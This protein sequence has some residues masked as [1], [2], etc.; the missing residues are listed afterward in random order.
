LPIQLAL[1]TDYVYFQHDKLVNGQRLNVKPSITLPLQNTSGFIIPKVSLQHTQYS[2]TNPNGTQPHDI[3]RTVPIVSVDSGLFGERELNWGEHSFT[4]TIEPRLFYLYIPRVKQN[5]IPVFDSSLYD[6]WYSNLF[7]ENRF[8]GLD[9]IQDAN[10]ITAAVSSRLIDSKTGLERLKLSIGEIFYLQ[11][12]DVTMPMLNKQGDFVNTQVETNKYSNLVT[13]LSSEI[14]RHL[15]VEAGLQWNP[16]SNDIQRGK[17]VLH[18]KDDNNRLLNL[19]YLYR[20]NPLLPDKSND[21]QQTDVSFSWPIYDTWSIVGRWQYSLLYNLTQEAFFGIEKE[22]C[23]WRF[24]LIGR[25][26]INGINNSTITDDPNQLA[27]GISQ[28]GIFFQIELKGLTGIG[29]K[30]DNFFEKSIYGYQK[31]DK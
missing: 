3:D 15:S 8:S 6:F 4:H 5:N 25:R 24:R 13:E 31:A 26:Y 7:R 17:A 21:I 12:R 28:T 29:E 14:N 30:L 10:Q 18:I 23:C 20:K 9:R 2:L 11:N 22:N 1:D 16:Q 19:G 27:Q